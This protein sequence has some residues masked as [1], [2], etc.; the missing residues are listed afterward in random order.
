MWDRKAT[1]RV[2]LCLKASADLASGIGTNGRKVRRA[3][4]SPMVQ[5]PPETIFCNGIVASAR[6]VGVG[7]GHRANLLIIED[8]RQ[9]LGRGGRIDRSDVRDLNCTNFQGGLVDADVVLA[10]KVSLG[11]GDRDHLRA[12]RRVCMAGSIA[13]LDTGAIS[14]HPV[15]DHLRDRHGRGE[16][17]A[18][19]QPV[20]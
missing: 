9:Q 1:L 11:A 3:D 12:A 15:A 13:A 19:L 8:L 7:G 2:H 14:G 17:R 6:D 18:R 4:N 20:G 10:P 5:A 16:R